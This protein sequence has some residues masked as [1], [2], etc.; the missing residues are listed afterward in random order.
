ML[1]Q[2]VDDGFRIIKSNKKKSQWVTEFNN[3]PEN[4][5]MDKWNFGNNV[6]FMDLFINKGK[7]F[8]VNGKLE[9]QFYQKH[10]NS[11]VCISLLKA[12]IQS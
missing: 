10:E 4:V 8:Y 3:L 6:M 5:S 11:Y 7:D 1:K 9:I 12:D 2:F